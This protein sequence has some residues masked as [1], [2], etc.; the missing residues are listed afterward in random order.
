LAALLAAHFIIISPNIVAT[1]APPKTIPMMIPPTPTVL[2]IFRQVLSPL[3]FTVQR[4]PGT[5]D[6]VAIITVEQE[7]VLPPLTE[8]ADVWIVLVVEQRSVP[9]VVTLVPLVVEEVEPVVVEVVAAA[10]EAAVLPVEVVVAVAL[11]AAAAE[12]A[13]AVDS[14]VVAADVVF[15]VVLA[16]VFF[17]VVVSDVSVAESDFMSV[18]SALLLNSIRSSFP[19]TSARYSCA[20]HTAPTVASAFGHPPAI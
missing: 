13:A 7:I 10:V 8:Q 20:N 3:L 18:E 15:A 6:A 17:S 9:V 11:E 1:M 19:C 16:V 5:Q 14:V 12:E 4:S 2:S